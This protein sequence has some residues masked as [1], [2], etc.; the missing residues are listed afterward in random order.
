MAPSE[1]VIESSD[2]ILL[3]GNGMHDP[4]GITKRILDTRNT[5]SYI[6]QPILFNE[7][8]HFEFESESNN[9]VAAL[10]QRLDGDLSTLGLEQVE[11]LLTRIT[12]MDTRIRPST[13]PSTPHVKKASSGS[14]SSGPEGKPLPHLRISLSKERSPS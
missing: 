5:T 9:F 8:D 3:H 2:F 1:K 14:C 11:R 7:D 10:E 4:M 12:S 6:G 13:G